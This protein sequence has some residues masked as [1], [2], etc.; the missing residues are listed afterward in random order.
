[1]IYAQQYEFFT[2]QYPNQTIQLGGGAFTF[3]YANHPTS[4]VTLILFAGGLG[5]GDG[6]YRHFLELAKHYSVITFNY[7][8]DFRTNADL[9]QSFALLIQKLH[10]KKVYLVGQSYGGFIAQIIAKRYPQLIT[11]MILSNTSTLTPHMDEAAKEN[12]MPMLKKAEKY[13]KLDKFLPLPLLKPLLKSG[14]KKKCKDMPSEK[15]TELTFLMDLFFGHCT[16]AHLLL[17]DTLLADL[18]N[19]CDLMSEDFVSYKNEVLLLLSDDDTTFV[20]SSKKALIEIM[21]SPVVNTSIKG[22]HL[23]GFVEFDNYLHAII[24]FINERNP[25]S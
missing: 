6:F 2:S 24:S 8:K 22:G 14:V 16:N 18:K 19:E 17:M 20:P 11:G 4:D 1:M 13:I 10:L 7:S 15:T 5:I 9:A 23:A 3:R 12:L 21:P 25:R